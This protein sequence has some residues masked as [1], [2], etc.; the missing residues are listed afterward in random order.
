MA[1]HDNDVVCIVDDDESLRRSLR[2]LLTSVGVQVETFGSAEAFLASE[3]L[4]IP[5][6]LVLDLRM[7]GM[8]GMELLGQLTSI[9]APHPA[10]VLTGHG[11]DE[12]R[13]RC[14]RAGAIA[15]LEKPFQSDALLHAVARAASTLPVRARAATDAPANRSS[16]SQNENENLT[17]NGSIQFAG[18][19][20]ENH[21]HICAFFNG[22]DEE[23]RVLRS[24][25]KD[26]LDAGEKSVHIVD[27]DRRDDHLRWLREEG[28]DVEQAMA[29]GQLAVHPWADA[30][31]R[32]ERFDQDSM[33]A[34]V[35]AMLRANEA[36]DSGRTRV[37][38]HMEW[39]LLDKPG[40]E[41]LVEYEAR[42]NRLLSQHHTPVICA[43]DLSKF[44]ASVV[45]DVLRTHPMVIIGGVLQENPF[46]VSPE[47]FLVE[48][49]DRS[50]GRA[51]A[52][53]TS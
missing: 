37:V 10:I 1:T 32:D 42:A 47:Q 45:M 39:A 24:F 46:F 44:S 53:T 28:V 14:L 8:G 9:G 4:A 13:R 31:L 22:A 16:T 19:I 34:Y 6:C 20:L 18:H 21:C 48:I 26:G 50:C 5:C 11:D 33:L 7:P 41:D 12:T 36:S 29:T 43:Y 25:V 38:A 40:V 15:F 35:E 23:H 52:S 51:N 17:S 30:Y 3:Y 27:P 2:N 49:R